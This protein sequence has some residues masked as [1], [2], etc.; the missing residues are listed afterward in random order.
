MLTESTFQSGIKRL[1]NEF[2]EK[3]FNPSIERIKQ[4][5]EY[6]KDM[7]DEEFKQRIDWVLKNVSFA[8]SMADIFK[9]EVNI[10]NTWKEFDFSFLKGGDNNATDK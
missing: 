4:W 2:S 5:F 3:G 1:I 10:N 6:M 8:P 7:T 9:A